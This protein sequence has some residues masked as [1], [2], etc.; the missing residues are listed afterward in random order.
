MNRTR[1]RTKKHGPRVGIVGYGGTPALDAALAAREAGEVDELWGFNPPDVAMAQAAEAGKFSLWFELHRKA[2][3]LDRCR[4]W[5]PPWLEGLASHMRVLVQ[6]PEDWPGT[7]RFPKDAVLECATGRRYQ[8]SSMDWLMR[9]ALYVGASEVT[10]FGMSFNGDSEP[11]SARACLEYWI[12]VAEG[13]GVPVRLVGCF[14]LLRNAEI[15]EDPL[16]NPLYAYDGLSTK[17][18]GGKQAALWRYLLSNGADCDPSLYWLTPSL[19]AAPEDR[20]S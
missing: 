1:K 8:T 2:D 4:T 14:H 6:E 20:V 13:R 15:P 12:G 10:F 9:Y 16:S 17:S 18:G 11:D 3:H 7:E 5:Y 19:D